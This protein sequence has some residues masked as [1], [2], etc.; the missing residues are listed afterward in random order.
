[1]QK[2]NKIDISKYHDLKEDKTINKNI[3][4]QNK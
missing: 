3:Y 4:K 1:M 2:Y